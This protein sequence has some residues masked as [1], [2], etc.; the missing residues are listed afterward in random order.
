MIINN[1]GE[2]PL[3]ILGRMNFKDKLSQ[4]IGMADINEIL[5]LIGDNDDRKRELYDLVMGDDE[6]IG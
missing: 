3:K 1:T 6:A 2:I 5:C 4:R